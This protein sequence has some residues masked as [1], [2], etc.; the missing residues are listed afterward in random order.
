VVDASAAGTAAG[1]A[2]P[3]VCTVADAVATVRLDRPEAMNS[4]TRAT[5]EAL[6]ATLRT[7]ADDDAVRAVV[8][9]GSGRAFCVGQDLREHV[10]DLRAADSA[11]A[12]DVGT[13]PAATLGGTVREHYNPITTLL[14]TM[15]KPVLAAVNGVAAGAGASFA[16][17]C[18]LRLLGASG[19]FNLAFA[20]IGLSCDSGAS[21]WLPRL[22]GVARAKELL[23]LPQTVPAAEALELGLATRVVPDDELAAAAAELA[24]RLAA[25]P[26][27]AYAAIR[28]AVAY[29]QGHDLHSSL[30]HEAGLMERTGATTDHRGAVEAFV[31]KRPPTFSGA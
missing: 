19:A 18:D 9:T 29:S 10:A 16:F 1:G 12:A 14:S 8:L 28:R 20:G 23:L 5:K 7:V 11:T 22:V 2:P 17:A 24:A 6:L 4:L 27:Q 21:W 25:G 31:A 3:V 15:P 13:D 26:T 30:E